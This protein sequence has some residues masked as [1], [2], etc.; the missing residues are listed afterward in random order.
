VSVT[1]ACACDAATLLDVSALVQAGSA[2]A[3]TIT[4]DATIDGASCNQY[5]LPEHTVDTLH[6]R[7]STSAAIYIPGGMHVM[8]DFVVETSQGAQLDIFIE[9]ELSVDGQITFGDDTD[10][11][12]LYV[13]GAGTL[14]LAGGGELHAALYA[15][16][17]E[18]V[19]GAPLTV[20]GGVFV[21]RVAASADIAIHYDAT[22]A[23]GP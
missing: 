18:L 19:L 5:V 10:N 11:V 4:A 16:R 3:R 13:G 22:L 9:D 14:P 8:Q 6:V 2:N 12:R 23:R 20:Y 7:A 17:A 15:P 1:P 21:R